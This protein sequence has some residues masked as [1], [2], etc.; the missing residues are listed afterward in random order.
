MPPQ[1][2]PERGTG[3]HDQ[4]PR[5]DFSPPDGSESL[6]SMYLDRAIEEDRRMVESWKEHANGMLTSTGLFS[7]AVAALLVV[8]IPDIRPNSQDTS[9]FYLAH[10]YQQSSTQ[11][12]GSRP[13]IPSSLSDPTEPFSPPKLSVWVNGLW[14]SS[15]VINLSCALLATLLQQWARRYEKV[16][17]PRYRPHKRARIR[18]FYRD[19]VERW[20][21]P[22]AVEALPVLLHISIFLFFA[23]I[24]V[25]LFGVH[26]TIFKAVTTLISLI[27]ISYTCLALSPV[28]HMNCL[29]FTPLSIPFSFC[30]TATRFLFFRILPGFNRKQLPFSQS[31]VKAA[32]KYALELE[33]DIDH[34]SLLW[35]FESLDNDTDFEEFFDALP[36]LC[37]SDR[38]T[39]EKLELK[40][41]FIEPNKSEL[42]NALMRLMDRTLSSN[43]VEESVKYRRMVIFI[44]AMDSK[45]TSLLDRSH[46]LR[47]VF[48]STFGIDSWDTWNL[49]FPCGFGRTISIKSRSHLSTRNA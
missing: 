10:I 27:V 29:Y 47:R 24:S 40:E 4:T 42:S 34:D 17:N 46:I 37:D 25:F 14:F 9:A 39:G 36:L 28:F 16:A 18:A 8:S 15:L 22:E 1:P 43:L 44:K 33:P 19:G 7:A 31:M 48:F 23:G 5:G 20:G 26:R 38:D 32:E 13:S 6:F 49:G 11:P 2:D 30:L 12:N 3:E 41:K 45:S 21:I 35:T